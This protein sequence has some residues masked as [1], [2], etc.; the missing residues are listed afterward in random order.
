MDEKKLDLILDE[1]GKVNGRLDR[2]ESLLTQLIKMVAETN[3]RRN[4]G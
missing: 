1:L 3:Q 2:H 4:V